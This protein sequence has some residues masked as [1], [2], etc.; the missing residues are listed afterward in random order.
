MAKTALVAGVE[1]LIGE[2]CAQLVGASKRYDKVYV[3]S[4]AKLKTKLPA[5]VENIVVKYDKLSSLKKAIKADDVFCCFSSEEKISG[6]LPATQT[7]RDLPVQLAEIMLARGAEQFLLTSVVGAHPASGIYSSKMR[8]E[9]EDTIVPM[10]FHG[11]HIFQISALMDEDGKN[12]NLLSYLLN[13]I[14]SSNHKRYDPTTSTNVAE[15]M[16]AVAE[17]DLGGK[18]YHFPAKEAKSAA[19]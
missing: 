10:T 18:H 13:P 7:D 3:L 14:E 2:A 15:K 5:Q 6:D 19:S 9:M 1:T 16:L 12:A 4:N 17:N 11:L 8:G